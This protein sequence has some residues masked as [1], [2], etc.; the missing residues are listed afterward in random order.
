MAT[1]RE[2][3]AASDTDAALRLVADARPKLFCKVAE[4]R[5]AHLK[6]GDELADRTRDSYAADAARVMKAGGD[7]RPLAGTVKS[8]RKLRAACLWKA[9]EDLRESLARADRARKKGGPGELEALCLYDE[10]LPA[11][12]SRLAFLAG[13]Q[14]DPGTAKRRDKCHMQRHKLGRLPKNWIS[15]IHERA[16]DGIYGEAVALGILIPVR[17]SEIAERVR[18][19]LDDAGALVFEV[20]GS[21]VRDKGSGIAAHVEGIGQ[22]LRWLTLSAVDASRQEAFDWLRDR[23]Q[24]NGGKLTI[25]NGLSA[26]GISSAF[27]AL[28]KRLS[29]RLKS[30]P[31]FYALRHAAC[32]ELKSSGIGPQGV[33]QGMGHASALSQK[34]YGTRSQGSSC[35]EVTVSASNPVRRPTVSPTPLSTFMPNI[36]PARP[37][38]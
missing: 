26:S 27:R 22:P 9:R 34:A 21:K 7:P 28:S 1:L 13:L 36:A 19:K 25:G 30:P 38:C 12:E 14:F 23:V 17:P 4:L 3:L 24:T 8:F 31:S 20:K 11:I 29:P 32:A 10:Q 16:C 33:A 35:Y 37:T 2:K 6:G 15:R 18:V 5:D